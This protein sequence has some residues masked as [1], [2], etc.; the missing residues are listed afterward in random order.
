M[1]AEPLQPADPMQ[2]SGAVWCDEHERWE[3]SRTS[4][5]SQSRCH[6]P[7][8]RGRLTCRMH[9][10]RSTAIEKALGE[11]S[12]L[13]WSTSAD[14]PADL[15]PL[16]P[17]TVV[18]EQLRVAV[19]RADLYGEMLRW[20]LEVEDEAGLVGVTFAA[21]RE[22]VRVET[23]ERARGLAVLEAGERDRVVRFAKTA[24]DMGIAERHVEL[25]QERASLVTSAFRGSIASIAD[26]LLP[27]DRDLMMRTF[28]TLLGAGDAVA[29][30]VEA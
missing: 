16:D 22:G 1:T 7:A 26:R 6:A 24:H 21:G 4:K 23:G 27:A 9:A 28:L 25:E 12:L 14:R 5:R 30:E 2:Q 19:M 15:A 29:G 3:C 13:A 11:A 10:G 20:Q 17:G 18:L 8:I